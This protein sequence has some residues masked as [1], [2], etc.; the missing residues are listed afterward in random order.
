MEE[1]IIL[2]L[3]WREIDEYIYNDPPPDSTDSDAYTIWRKSD[4]MAGGIIFMG[5]SP[6]HFEHIPE[7][8][9]E[10]EKW[11][12][13]VNRFERKNLLKKLGACLPFYTPTMEWRKV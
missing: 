4:K 6:E 7:E 10:Q 9:T 12:A 5:I 11:D 3:E 1:N 8:S 13:I 2:L